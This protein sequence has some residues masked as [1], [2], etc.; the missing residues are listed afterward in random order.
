MTPRK[1]VLG[2]PATIPS[3][4]SGA[5]AMQSLMADLGVQPMPVRH[6]WGRVEG[7]QERARAVAVAEAQNQEQV[8]VLSELLLTGLKAFGVGAVAN[9]LPPRWRSVSVGFGLSLA[10]SEV[11]RSEMPWRTSLAFVSGCASGYQLSRYGQRV[12]EAL[13][14]RRALDRSLAELHERLC[15]AHAESAAINAEQRAELMTQ[16]AAQDQELASLKQNIGVLANAVRDNEVKMA[17]LESSATLV[18]AVDHLPRI[19][20]VENLVHAMSNDIES[21]QKRAE[22][23]PKNVNPDPGVQKNANAISAMQKDLEKMQAAPRVDASEVE[24]LIAKS[25]TFDGSQDFVSRLQ[26][27]ERKM[28][29]NRDDSRAAHEDLSRRISDTQQFADAGFQRATEA[30][31]VAAGAAATAGSAQ[32]TAANSAYQIEG[33]NDWA[34][35]FE[36]RVESVSKRNRDAIRALWEDGAP[37]SEEPVVA[38]A[39]TTHVTPE[40]TYDLLRKM[41]KNEVTAQTLEAKAQDN[42]GLSL[43]RKMGQ[44]KRAGQPAKNQKGAQNS[45]SRRSEGGRKCDAK[46][47]KIT[48][49]K[50]SG[51]GGVNG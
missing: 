39:V 32:L 2:K 4:Y 48:T 14:A 23:A 37:R 15:D 16:R 9:L 21:L 47:E 7:N 22:S 46:A 17:E 36:D 49:Y 24:R 30:Q 28:K 25:K 51:T 29:R 20:A 6:E 45:D 10:I 11:R 31:R 13:K 12:Y 3:A 44:R 41:V 43:V 40:S 33:I 26:K 38:P 27:L 42:L 50:A 34:D 18:Q 1:P 8:A 5:S 35:N 19:Q